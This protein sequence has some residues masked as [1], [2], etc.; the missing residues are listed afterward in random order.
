M[1]SP[2]D[3][4]RR[5]FAED[6]RVAAPVRHNEAVLEAFA[7]VP[8]E[9]FCG[10]GPWQIHPRRIGAPP[11]TTENAA[12]DAL[13]HDVLVTI[14]KERDLNNGQPSLWAFIFDQLDL[15]PGQSVLQIGA[16]TG[17][18]TAILAEIVGPKGRVESVELDPTLARRAE[19]A[20]VPW[21]WASVRQGNGAKDC[22]GGR[23]DAIIVFAGATGPA[24]AWLDRLATG[25]RLLMPLT[26]A[27]GWG[28]LL[29]LERTPAGFGAGTL[30]R[31]G[32]FHCDG[33]RHPGEESRLQDALSSLDG[34]EVPVRALHLGKAKPGA[35]GV[36]LQG[37]N[38]WLSTRPLLPH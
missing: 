9:R 26:A 14:D 11:Y 22:D 8:R 32:F 36:W 23:V 16:G 5:W 29:R 30:G 24:A 2:I 21:P 35:E 15:A 17:Y 25:G 13:Y 33:A 10:N 7:R 20:L 18:Y 34:E 12:P 27:N 1:N 4:L 6:L 38:Y 19:E 3:S 28:F 37:E 31:C